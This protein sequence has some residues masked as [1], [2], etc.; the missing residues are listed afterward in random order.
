MAA[1]MKSARIAG[2]EFMTEE[3]P[4]ETH[5][6]VWPQAFIHGVQAVFGTR[7]FGKTGARGV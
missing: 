5:M 3:F 4:G 1:L 6:T 2:L 7:G